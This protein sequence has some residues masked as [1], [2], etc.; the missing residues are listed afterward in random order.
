MEDEDVEEGVEEEDDVGLDG[1]AV[2]QHGLWWDV[3]CVRHE[4]GLDHDE[5]VV[6]VLLV[7]HMAKRGEGVSMSSSDGRQDTYR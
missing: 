6:D 4:R 5:R 1:N 3:E 2:E 7:E